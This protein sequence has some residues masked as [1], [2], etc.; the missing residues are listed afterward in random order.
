MAAPTLAEVGKRSQDTLIQG[1]TEI[2]AVNS[3]VLMRLPLRQVR[4][5]GAIWN[6]VTA[7]V[8]PSWGSMAG[9]A[10]TG[11]AANPALSTQRTATVKHLYGRVDIGMGTAMT[12]PMEASRQINYKVSQIRKEWLRSFTEADG[13]ANRI[14]GLG[15]L[16][17]TATP[18]QTME[19]GTNGDTLT[20]AILD[21]LRL[22]VYTDD[23]SYADFLLMHS[24]HY[25]KFLQLLQ[26]AG[27][28][29]IQETRMV[30]AGSTYVA[31]FYNGAEVI[32]SDHI[33]N[34]TRGTN[35]TKPIYAGKWDDGTGTRGL[36]GIYP[37]GMPTPFAMQYGGVREGHTEEFYWVSAFLGLAN[38][39]SQ[40]LAVRQHVVLT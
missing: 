14:T 13:T 5:G 23:G 2:F 40:A 33:G 31:E 38:F 6:E 18:D 21:R 19:G 30:G 28:A 29:L 7:N 17:S 12:D 9:G 8:L 36:A 16:V 32:I 37:E 24:T 10:I 25:L 4:S 34:V 27:G 3:P 22:S 15:D 39:N 20:L 11:T 1:I 26:A 35:Q